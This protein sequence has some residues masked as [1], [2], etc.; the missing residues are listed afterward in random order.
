MN[1]AP[2]LTVVAAILE[3][4]SGRVLL[5]ERPH[6]KPDAGYWEFP[7]GKIE[8]GESPAQAL[9]RELH[10]ELGIELTRAVRLMSVHQVRANGPLELQ[11]WRVLAYRGEVCAR[12]NQALR[13]LPA[14]ALPA[15]ELCPADRPI[16][17]A[18]GLPD[19]LLITPD[20]A[21]LPQASFLRCVDAAIGAGLSLVRLRSRLPIAEDLITACEARMQATGGRLLLG[22]A[23]FSRRQSAC[24]GLYLRS[25]ELC[26]RLPMPG[27]P[28]SLVL[29]SV[30]DAREIASAHDLGVD[31]LVIAPVLATASHPGEACLGWS[32]F[33]SLLAQ[34]R[35]PA[36]ALGG[37]GVA[38]L[39]SARG[40]GALGIAAIRGLWPDLKPTP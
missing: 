21:D 11:A 29:A 35:L 3:D 25:R 4:R 12:E 23:D 15:P 36:Y 7:G 18:L 39:P 8:S 13:W 2:G 17:R 14:N 31:A 16:A 37:L 28:K 20:P 6:G 26:P 27:D 33:A 10:E 34:S 9:A 22:L 24:T 40:H 5:A 32:G 1:S 38:D 30:H 19:R